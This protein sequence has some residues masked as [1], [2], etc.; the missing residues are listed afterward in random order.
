MDCQGLGIQVSSYLAG[1][2]AKDLFSNHAADYA[3]FRPQF[4]AELIKH[5][6][7]LV[8][9]RGVAWDC[10]TGNGQLAVQLER[11]FNLVCASDISAAQIKE[12][13]ARG[14]IH[15]SVQPAE[16]TDY[17]DHFFDLITVGQAIHWLN[18]EAFY[19]EAK[20]VLRPGAVISIMGYSLCRVN[21]VIDQWIDHFYHEVVGPFWEPERKIIDTGYASLEFPFEPIAVPAFKMSALWSADQFLGYLGTWSACKKYQEAIGKDPVRTNENSLRSHWPAGSV[22]EVN[23]P[24]LLRVGRKA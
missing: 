15:Y 18:R 11:Y 16:S 23:F 7:S 9:Y 10:A 1:M 14:G 13:P 19:K 6:A 8:N 4:P 17:P 2:R 22:L 12:A 21:P 3:S 24:L 5:L 20:R